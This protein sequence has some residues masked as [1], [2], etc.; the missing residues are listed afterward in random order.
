MALAR[1]VVGSLVIDVASRVISEFPEAAPTQGNSVLG[2]FSGCCYKID[3]HMSRI[4]VTIEAANSSF[5]V[6]VKG[7][8]VAGFADDRLAGLRYS[9]SA[10]PPALKQINWR[11]RRWERLRRFAFY[12]R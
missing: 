8:P 12:S 5:Y 9:P 6:T 10:S 7:Q 1:V 11:S 4:E 2:I 3:T